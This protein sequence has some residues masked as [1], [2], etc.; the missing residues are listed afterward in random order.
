MYADYFGFKELPF[1]N[2]PDPRF[3][4]ATPDHEEALA[5]LVYAVSERKGFVLLTGEV[6]TGKTLVTRMMLRHF[7]TQLAFAN[8]NHVVQ[9]PVELMESIC[10]EFELSFRQGSS[11]TRLVRMLHDFL[12]AQFSQNIPVVLVL[13]EAQ[14]L[15]I[16]GFEQLRMIGNLE[17]DDAKLLQIAIVGQ[18]ELQRMFLSPKLRQL[19]QRVFRSF[20][21]SAL[22]RDV[23]EEYIKH[24]LSIVGARCADVMEPGAIDTVFRVSQG[25]PRLINTVCDNALLSAYSADR[26][27]ID[28]A[29]I[30]SV[31]S[32]MM[33]LTEPA[34]ERNPWP[35]IEPS[36]MAYGGRRAA[37][38]AQVAEARRAPQE[39][40]PAGIVRTPAEASRPRPQQASPAV[41]VGKQPVQAGAAAPQI[42][43]EDE[44]RILARVHQAVAAELNA[45]RREVKARDV[46][47]AAR[48]S[49]IERRIDDAGVDLTETQAGHARLERLVQHATV[50]AAHLESTGRDLSRRDQQVRGLAS[51]VKDVVRDLR[52]LLDRAKE[53]TAQTTEARRGA[54]AAHGRLVTEIHRSREVADELTRIANRTVATAWVSSARHAEPGPTIVPTPAAPT[55]GIETIRPERDVM[56]FVQATDPDRESLGHPV[57]PVQQMLEDARESLSDLRHLARTNRAPRYEPDSQAGMEPA[58]RLAREVEN[59]LEIVEPV[60]VAQQAT[61]V[62]A[63]ETT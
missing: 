49:Q 48:L 52:R 8:I 18:P 56:P 36:R 19:R 54:R 40:A 15:T 3:F 13:D 53:T 32:Q 61:P 63:E 47:A 31:M 62:A 25:L 7:G 1:N 20:H 21:L 50:T 59:L 44:N 16:D 29:F 34:V 30:E 58:A 37:A 41:P 33:V 27:T 26:S 23:T 10:T 35:S 43:P 42:R 4:Y 9:S 5:S 14:N 51:V 28:G 39:T 22:S 24:R 57:V 2:T 17:A 60:S 11:A 12:L 55:G 6:G 45:L 46:E 38:V